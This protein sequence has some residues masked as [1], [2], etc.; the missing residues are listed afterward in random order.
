MKIF[1]NEKLF[2]KIIMI[3]L[4]I[5]VFS[6]F[7]PKGVEAKDSSLGGKLLKPF[8]DL[9]LSVNDGIYDVVHQVILHQDRTL[10][11]ISLTST[12]W[13]KI[14][15][16]LVFIGIAVAAAVA[17]VATAGAAA[18]LATA[19]AGISLSAVSAGTVIFV[20]VA[21][22][23]I[24]AALYNANEF[25]DDKLDLPLY[26]ISPEEIFSNK[27][28]IFDVDFFNPEKD[29]TLKEGDTTTNVKGDDGKPVELESTAKKLRA[30]I[31]NWYVILRDIAVVALLSILVYVGI[32]IIIS[33]TSGEKA[34]YKQMLVDWIV[35]MC[36]LFVMQYIMSFSN[37]LVEKITD[38]LN[39]IKYENKTIQILP[40]KDDKISKEL[41]EN[42]GFSEDQVDGMFLKDENGN[43]QT[44]KDEENKKEYNLIV[45]N[46]NLI[47]VARLNAQMAQDKTTTYAGYT[48][49][50]AVLVLM[51]IFF[52]FTY[53]KRVIYMAFLTLIAPLVAMT[54]P[55]DKM[56]DGKA[57]AFDSWFKEYIFNLLIQPMHLLLYTILVSSAFELATTN[58]IYS[59]VAIAFMI[60]A[61][62]LLRKF[63]GFEKAH[64]PGL[65]A[66]PA[67]AAAT[68]SVVNKLLGKAPRAPKG[69]N[70][71]N[72]SRIASGGNDKNTNIKYKDD[73][74]SDSLLYGYNDKNNQI[75]SSSGNK[76]DNGL[77]EAYSGQSENYGLIDGT[78]NTGY[79]SDNYL[80][81]NNATP[82]GIEN[83]DN[84]NSNEKFENNHKNEDLLESESNNIR[85]DDKKLDENPEKSSGDDYHEE[86][87]K[88]DKNKII[89]SPSKSMP[90][91]ALEGARNSVKSLGRGALAGGKY[92]TKGMANKISER[93]KNLHPVK[94]TIRTVGGLAGAAV[95]GSIGLAAG[96][97]SGDP[98][99]VV[100]YGGAAALGGYKFG[101]GT[102]GTVSNALSV[103][104]TM[105][106]MKKGYYGEDGYKEKQIQENIKKTQKDDNL[107]KELETRL[108]DK[109]KAKDAMETVAPDCVRYGLTEANE[110]AA[111][112]NRV[113]DGNNVKRAIAQVNEAK[114]F[115]KKTSKMGHKDRED[116]VN[117][118]HDR[119]EKNNRGLTKEQKKQLQDDLIRN[120]D[121]A[122]SDLYKKI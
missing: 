115:G 72:G 103:D 21:A 77:Q 66:G 74:N 33:S 25:P 62:K 43:K 10:L 41:K 101:T 111:V 53:L 50:F 75:Y 70:G 19:I 12:F 6:F 26:S 76:N 82:I 18:A 8:V 113:Q 67:G 56:N 24:G 15:T 11:P 93:A 38:I 4:I 45:W 106:E 116:Y 49:I 65:L 89:R 46:T 118:I 68:M 69:G 30:T 60:P 48:L 114:N 42:Y 35:A 109:N 29:K 120:I 27:L 47:G 63:F 108:K 31:S 55:I 3:F 85:F 84:L 119:I 98:S 17:I 64:T 58:M 22:G 34:K 79:E 16:V 61:E 117:T 122:S 73:I 9:V 86:Q 44:A 105:N 13:E 57:Q 94:G 92:Y 91:I 80:N 39:D 100:Q 28:V 40:D 59:I 52:I 99:K 95:A 104:G 97:V 81:D 51:T 90:R 78:Q 36:L 14:S 37:M 102:V 83:N 88:S 1:E 107:K 112:Y 87:I 7:M 96:V 32:K 54:Y 23:T 20:S 121:E 71:N 5:I 110:I 2:K